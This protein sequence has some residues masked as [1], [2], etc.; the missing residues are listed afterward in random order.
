[1]KML[2]KLSLRH[3]EEHDQIDRL[4]VQRV[5]IDALGRAAQCADDFL[6]QVRRGVGN[7][8]AKTYAGA[9]GG[10]ALFDHGDDGVATFRPNFMSCDQVLD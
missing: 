3:K 6:D 5:E 8:D 1:M 9:H 10:L 2:L 7:A 4:I